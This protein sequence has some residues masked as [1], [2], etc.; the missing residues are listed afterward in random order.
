MLG[1]S[2]YT[3]C[4]SSHGAQASLKL[5]PRLALNSVSFC[6]GFPGVRT[7]DICYRPWLFT[8]FPPFQVMF[9]Y[10]PSARTLIYRTP[11]IL[12]VTSIVS[13]LTD[14]FKVFCVFLSVVCLSVCLQRPE[15]LDLPVV[16]GL[17]SCQHQC[18]DVNSGSVQVHILSHGAI[19]A[20]P[21]LCFISSCHFL[22]TLCCHESR[23]DSKLPLL[24]RM[25]PSI[26]LS[27]WYLGTI[28]AASRLVPFCLLVRY[29]VLGKAQMTR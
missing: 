27:L 25:C 6:L 11:F 16:G 18:W 19:S 10:F 4:S 29:L 21:L 22:L 13:S 2:Y 14:F 20:D 12:S 3:D 9:P 1:H 24:L 5:Q 23:R 7:T 17:G 28:A 8:F 15:E 26:P